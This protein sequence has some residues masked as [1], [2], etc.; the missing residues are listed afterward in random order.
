MPLLISFT[1]I[2]LRLTL[3]DELSSTIIMFISFFLLLV[4]YGLGYRALWQWSLKRHKIDT[5][6][7]LKLGTVSIIASDLIIYASLFKT[8][9]TLSNFTWLGFYLLLI[10]LF[11]LLGKRSIKQLAI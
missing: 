11:Y 10:A 4:L 3:Q 8:G 6:K 2:T 1:D 7:L 5:A 9:H